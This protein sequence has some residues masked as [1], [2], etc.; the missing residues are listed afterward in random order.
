MPYVESLTALDNKRNHEA[1]DIN[2]LTGDVVAFLQNIKD[3][4]SQGKLLELRG[5][6][7]SKVELVREFFRQIHTNVLNQLGVFGHQPQPSHKNE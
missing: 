7:L 6:D 3:L 4:A 1:L 2:Q 5:L